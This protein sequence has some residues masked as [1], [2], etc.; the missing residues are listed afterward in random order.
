MQILKNIFIAASLI[1]TLVLAIAFWYVAVA[2]AVLFLAYF[3]AASYTKVK[4][5]LN[6]GT[7]IYWKDWSYYSSFS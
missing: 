1:L 7:W 3:I 4:G 2:F 5:V 6:E